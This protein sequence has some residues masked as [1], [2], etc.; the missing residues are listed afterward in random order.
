MLLH[1]PVA[2][3]KVMSP[4]PK[5]LMLQFFPTP[6]DGTRKWAF[7]QW[8]GHDGKGPVVNL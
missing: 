2:V 8:L 7:G 6:C 4:N 5:F 1:S 3:G